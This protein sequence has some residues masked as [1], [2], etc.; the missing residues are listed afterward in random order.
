MANAARAVTVM[1]VAVACAVAGVAVA[2]QFMPPEPVESTE[3]AATVTVEVVQTQT[4]APVAPA[5]LAASPEGIYLEEH[6][7]DDPDSIWVV[8]N[9]T[10]PLDPLDHEPSGLVSAQL[11][12]ESAQLKRAAARALR[13]MFDAADAADAPFRVSSAYRSYGF[14]QGLY[15]N[16]VATRG[17][18]NADTFSARP[19]Y[20][21]HQT[22][23][24]ADLYD[25]AGCHLKGCYA[26]TKSGKWVTKHAADYGFIVRYPQ[27]E[28]DITGYMWEPWHLRYVGV[29]LAQY[30]R[31]QQIATL[32]EVFGLPAAPDYLD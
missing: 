10:R 22:G 30:M 29:E 19:G 28:A 4:A 20:S 32:E 17:R 9:K 14:Q 11:P 1:T 6:S 16:Y 2:A 27:D 18:A 15:G 26:E 23:L 5:P 12:G 3:P 31:D 24:A 25:P 7:I 13:R 21:E 8:V